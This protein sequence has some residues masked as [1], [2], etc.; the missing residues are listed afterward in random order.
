MPLQA[1]VGLLTGIL[2]F[3]S[4]AGILLLYRTE[5]QRAA[6]LFQDQAHKVE[7]NFDSLVTL[8]GESLRSMSVDYTYWDDM[9]AFVRH[10]RAEWA[11]TNIEVALPTY[12]VATVWV[13]RP[14]RTLVYHT[15]TIGLTGLREIPVP[16][17]AFT[18]LFA[19]G[20][21]SHFFISTTK[22]FIEIR[23]ATIHPTQDEKRTQPPRGY[24]FVGRLWDKAALSELAWL[25]DSAIDIRSVGD[26]PSTAGRVTTR[27]AITFR[28]PLRSW[29]GRPLAFVGVRND[30]R[31]VR[32]LE[33]AGMRTV[34][35]AVASAA[36]SLLLFW[37]FLSAWI[38]R[39]VRLLSASLS[40]EDTSHLARLQPFDIR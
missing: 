34:M 5:A 27:H 14:D 17:L 31:I 37:I 40:R 10:G 32:T 1:R 35:L 24:L 21:F 25:T 18:R 29:A 11:R 19:R 33:R 30:A 12:N 13:Y 6:L 23:G 15:N 9:V 20:P 16:K 22:G 3:V 38:S 7:T 8:K 39:P 4:S 2:V 26:T 28:R 36:A